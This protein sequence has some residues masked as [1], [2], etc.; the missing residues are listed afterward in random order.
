MKNEKLQKSAG[1]LLIRAEEVSDSKDV[2]TFC[3]SG[4]GL[5]KKDWFGKSDPYLEFQRCNE[6]NTYTVVHRT[7]VIKNTL[8][9]IWKVFT[10]PVQVLCNGDYQR[11]IKVFCYDWNMNGDTDLIGVF[12]T[13]LEDLTNYK[14]GKP[15]SYDIY[16]VNNTRLS[17]NKSGSIHIQECRVEQRRSFFDYI[18]GGLALNFVVAVDFT[19]SNG[20]PNDRSSLH[21]STPQTPSQYVQVLQSIGQLIE[22]YDADKLFPSFGFGAKLPPSWSVS[23]DFALNF[24]PQDP[25]CHGVEG[26]IAAYY[27][28]ILS[29][30]LYGPTNF[31]PVI[32]SCVGIARTATHGA[33]YFVLLI[34][35]DGIISDMNKTKQAIIEAAEL[36]ISIIIGKYL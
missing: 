8:N 33:Q 11:N 26:I 23:H 25:H 22:D 6:D 29:V 35:T 24:N 12:E 20:D 28:S 3:L 15:S 5:D 14:S 21:H 2:V 16:P 32:N 30:T 7:E 34:I 13:N 10:I 1:I 17:P 18:T 19:A 4:K 31:A 36:P 9:P 27:N